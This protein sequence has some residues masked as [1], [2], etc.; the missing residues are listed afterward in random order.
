MGV[1]VCH[2]HLVERKCASVCRTQGRWRIVS[3]L[4]CLCGVDK[5]IT[6]K[7]SGDTHHVGGL[8]DTT[9]D[10]FLPQI[11]CR[12]KR[13]S[14]D[15]KKSK[16][17]WAADEDEALLKAVLE[18]QQGRE[19]GGEAED[20]EDWD[21]IAKSVPGKTPVQCL[22]RYMMLNSKKPS[23]EPATPPMVP[24]AK[25]DIAEGEMKRSTSSSKPTKEEEE[26]DDDEEEDDE[27]KEDQEGEDESGEKE[28]K[29]ARSEADDVAPFWPQDETDLLKKL[30]E[31][32]KDSKY[33]FRL[34]KTVFFFRNEP[35]QL[36]HFYDRC[37]SLE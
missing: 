7:E 16:A 23:N 4:I 25:P 14:E 17:V 1:K 13:R 6:R 21:E 15:V 36:Y 28:S 5:Q 3:G 30:V 22:K 9:G 10:R 8:S 31:L 35:S 11:D 12:M 29:R 37:A 18:E 27:E 26:D 32:Y 20:E 33:F 2:I 19:S 24:A 34:S